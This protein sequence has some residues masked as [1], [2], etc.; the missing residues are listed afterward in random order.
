M[1][2]FSERTA[3]LDHRCDGLHVTAVLRSSVPGLPGEDAEGIL[4]DVE[5][6]PHSL[7]ENAQ[8]PIADAVNDHRFAPGSYGLVG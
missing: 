8:F 7:A 6:H 4:A 1:H 3:P 2:G 5:G